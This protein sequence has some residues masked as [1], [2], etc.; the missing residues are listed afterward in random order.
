MDGTELIYK[1]RKKQQIKIA[2]IE[3]DYDLLLC[4]IGVNVFY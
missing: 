2:I 3:I 1:N 4:K